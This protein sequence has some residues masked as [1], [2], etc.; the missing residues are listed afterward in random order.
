[1]SCIEH[2]T[3]PSI[4]VFVPVFF[5]VP[6]HVLVS[7]LGGVAG[8]S[9]VFAI[10]RIGEDRMDRPL[11]DILRL[12]VSFMNCRIFSLIKWACVAE[13]TRVFFFAQATP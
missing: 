7:V 5:P 13:S 2:T 8:F 6:V 11:L 12:T 1:M 9:F 3:G 10:V 4:R